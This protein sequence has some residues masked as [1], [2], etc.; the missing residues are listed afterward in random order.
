MTRRLSVYY[1]ISDL[2]ASAAAWA[3]FSLIRNRISGVDFTF[4]TLLTGKFIATAAVVS[5]SW[6]LIFAVTGFY[7][8]SLKRSRLAELA[9]SIAVTVTGVFIQFFIILSEGIISDNTQYLYF[10]EMLFV[11]QFS[12][13]YIPRLAITSSTARKVHKGVLGYNTII[14]GSN[15]KALEIFR[16]IKQ[17]KIPSGNI[18]KGFVSLK[19]E[20]AGILAEH[21]PRL[22]IL[23]D[24]PSIIEKHRIEEVIL[25]LE[26]DEHKT[27]GEVTG[28][29]EFSNITIKAIPSLKDYLTGRVE[30]SAI[31]GTPLLEISDHIM[32]V[33]QSAVKKTMDYSLALFML[34]ILSPFLVVVGIIIRLT[35]KGPV[36]FTQERIGKHG[37]PFRMYK[38]RSMYD[39]AEKGE[40]LLSSRA[41]PRVTAFG[42][43]MR[44]HRIDEIPNLINVLKGEM[45]LVGPRP[46]RQFFIDQ[47]VEKAPHYRRLLKVKPGITSWGQVK[48]GYASNVDQMVERLEYDLLYLDNMSL[49]IDMKIMIYT[50]LIIVKGKGV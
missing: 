3:L 50:I 25:A 10:L 20:E 27:I 9:Y 26:G 41:D 36:I 38:F 42:R 31:F 2:I 21:L 35:G 45:S 49:L 29:L 16:K 12:L 5:L 13:T 30:Q 14:I 32:P 7:S 1:I 11:L 17:E 37:K 8:V 40:P 18:L 33:W 44:K 6:V 22:G 48:Y 43:F 4:A 19:E 39:G 34:V 47:I 46:E 24:L 28:L 15:G 23:R